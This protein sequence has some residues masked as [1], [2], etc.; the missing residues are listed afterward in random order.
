MNTEKNGSFV[1]EPSISEGAL[2]S[3]IEALIADVPLNRN[4]VVERNLTIGGEVA[5]IDQ[6][7]AKKEL[8]ASLGHQVGDSMSVTMRYNPN[9]EA[10]DIHTVEFALPGTT[11][12]TAHADFDPESDSYSSY[13]FDADTKKQIARKPVQT[14]TIRTLVETDGFISNVTATT[15][16][17]LL[18]QLMQAAPTNME[19]T[20]RQSAILIEEE[21][22][23]DIYGACT[24][25]RTQT[26]S[27][28]DILD[29]IEFTNQVCMP[30]SKH[31]RVIKVIT[32]QH[33]STITGEETSEDETTG[34]ATF[35]H[36]D[37]DY[38]M[39]EKL[40]GQVDK[41]QA[42]LRRES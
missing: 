9:W 15:Q 16:S 18:I 41:A 5:S 19:L 32:S 42:A 20:I 21:V 38:E 12:L 10:F 29:V 2:K 1:R 4:T 14:S 34:K 7:R 6:M 33:G 26:Y 36:I 11:D 40:I 8:E 35:R 23:E 17:E 25:E 27:E 3:R 13:L 30:D 31:A 37:F 28:D 24:I 39:L 22:S